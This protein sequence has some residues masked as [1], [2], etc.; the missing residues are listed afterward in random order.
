LPASRRLKASREDLFDALQGEL[1][2]SHHFVL[3]EL[4]RH[5][6]E[7]EARIARFDARLLDELQTERATLVLLQTL[8]GVDLIGAAML[9]VEISTDMQAFMDE[10]VA[11]QP[12]DRQI[13]VI[14]DN[15]DTHKKNND[16]RAM[17]LDVTFHFTPTAAS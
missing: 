13:H 7:I 5:I 8:P 9:P 3:D 2:A 4:M 6:E 10:V 17:H 14:L 11:D 16:W 1:T 12:A 15:L